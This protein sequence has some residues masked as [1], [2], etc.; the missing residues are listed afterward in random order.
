MKRRI[1]SGLLFIWLYMKMRK[2]FSAA[3]IGLLDA[4]LPVGKRLE[5]VVV[6][7]LEGRP[8]DEDR[9]EERD[10]H[11]HLARRHLLEGESALHEVEDDG[12]AQEARDEDEDARRQR[13]GGKEEEELDR[14]SD[15]LPRA[16]VAHPEVDER[17]EGYG[18]R[19]A[20]RAP[21][22]RAR[23]SLARAR[24]RGRDGREGLGSPS[25]ATC[26][27]RRAAACCA[28]GLGGSGDE[29]ERRRTK[30]ADA[31][32]HTL[33]AC[34]HGGHQNFLS[35]SRWPARKSPERC[36]ASW[37]S[38]GPGAGPPMRPAEE[39]RRSPCRTACG[40]CGRLSDASR[41]SASMNSLSSISATSDTD[42]SVAPTR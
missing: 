31:L 1:F 11:E 10:A 37:P 23:R 39:C 24:G 17:H 15:F 40:P 21:D 27:G 32:T 26:R 4:D 29:A 9:E 8:H 7:C 42:A 19:Q 36:A 2:G 5:R 18:R 34:F 38:P 12:D 41:A 13:E 33:R 28:R 22:A 35:R 25:S 14:E 20:R 30:A 6:D 3:L 16:R